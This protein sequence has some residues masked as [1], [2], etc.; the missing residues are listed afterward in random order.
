[1]KGVER[2]LGISRDRSV[3]EVDGF[4]AVRLW[5]RYQ[6]GSSAALKKLLTYNE[7]DTRNLAQ[8]ASAIY[9]RLCLKAR[10]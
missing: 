1:M 6:K 5:R 3:V 9:E 4:E 2:T 10:A 7:A 8:M